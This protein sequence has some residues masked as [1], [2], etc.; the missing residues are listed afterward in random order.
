M[1][2]R[3]KNERPEE[4]YAGD[5]K[6]YYAEQWT[7]YSKNNAVRTTQRKLT[8][9]AAE[10]LMAPPGTKVLDAGCGNG[11]SMEV[12]Q[13]LGY[14]V[15]GFDASRELTAEAVK[16]GFSVRQGDFTRMPYA[17]KT[18]DYAFSISALQWVLAKPDAERRIAKTARE[19]KRVLRKEGRAVL[20]FY[21]KSEE[22]LNEAGRAFRQAGFKVTIITDNPDNAIKRRVFLL[23]ALEK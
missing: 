23:L 6:R 7:N 10:L 20:Q 2:W 22:A 9:R 17:D 18:F 8:L 14:K 12:L 19:F 15:K 13:E 11:F 3:V 4:D 5:A 1:S 21:P 16:T